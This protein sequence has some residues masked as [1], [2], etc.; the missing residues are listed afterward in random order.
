MT[1]QVRYRTQHGGVHNALI[2]SQEKETEV[3]MMPFQAP[4]KKI[5][6]AAMFITSGILLSGCV[7][8]PAADGTEAIIIEKASVMPALTPVKGAK[9]DAVARNGLLINPSVREAASVISASADQVRV[10]R[11]ALFPGLS[12]AA[13]AGVGSGSTGKPGVDLTGSQLLF[14]GGNSKRA[15]KLADFDLQINYIA[16]Q[17]TVDDSLLEILKIYADVQMKSEL[18]DVYKS[19][20]KALTELDKLVAERATNGA[21]SSSDHLETRKRVQSAA[22]LAN[23][24]QLELGEAR[25]R[26]TLLTGTPQ[27]GRV[28]ISTQ[29]CKGRGETDDMRMIRLSQARAQVA[30]EKAEKEVTPRIALQPVVGGELGVNKLPLG[31]NVDVRSDFLQ[32]G[33]LT[34][35]AN[36]ARNNLAGTE[37]KLAF[38]QLQD[39]LKETALARSLAAGEMKSTML[40]KQIE[41]LKKTRVLYREQYF[42]MGTRQLSDLLDNEEEYYGRQAELAK[43]RTEM[44]LT[45][46][47]CAIRNRSLREELKINGNS[48]HGYPLSSELI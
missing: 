20:L 10:Q 5:R 18:L 23:D 29:S 27:G 24:T 38:V 25:D 42:D 13:G 32:G 1:A 6:Q 19:Q 12:V 30:L 21:V 28:V 43:L 44:S 22:F 15:V 3:Q 4:L 34:A 14:D 40:K 48:I 36:V 16:F 2:W 46:V 41:L 9:I 45:Q 31:L 26:L 17:K 35:R 39:N 8:L 47:Q 7:G 11:A 37:A 33:A